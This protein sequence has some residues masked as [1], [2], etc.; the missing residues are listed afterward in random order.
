[1]KRL[2]GI[3]T[4]KAAMTTTT[5]AMASFM[6]CEVYGNIRHY[7]S[8]CHETQENV[9]YMNDNNNG[10]RPQQGG[11]P[12]NQQC[13]YYQGGNQGIFFNPNQPFLKNLV[14]VKAKIKRML[15]KR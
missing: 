4:E 13:P 1:M 8:H 9:M 11:Q 14:Y 2:D 7:G 5:R 3:T 12:W 15:T 10:Y 6:T